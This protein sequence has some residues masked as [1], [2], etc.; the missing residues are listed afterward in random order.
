MKPSLVRLLVC[1]GCGSGL[2][3]RVSA[4]SGAEAQEGGLACRGCAAEYPVVR[5]VPRFVETGA[6]AG[7]FG[8]QWN[9]FR[10]VQ[11][12]SRN[13]SGESARTFS[14]TTGWSEEDVRGKVVLDAGVGAGRFAE[15]VADRGGEVIGIDITSAV[16]AAYENVGRR[17]GVHVIQADIFAM[18]LR[19]GSFDLAYSIGVLHHTPDTRKAF[20]RV[21]SMVRP[22]GQF[23]V[24]L[25]ARYGPS[26]RC[27]DAIR[28]LTTRLPLWLMLR[29]AFL[30]APLYPLYRLP[31]I[32]ALLRLLFP[33]SM[34]PNWRWRWLDTFDWYSP[35]YQ[36][37][38]LYPEV[39]RWFRACGFHDI[40]IFDDPIRMRGTREPRGR[41]LEVPS[42][43][44]FRAVALGGGTGLPVVLQGLKGV[45]FP[46]PCAPSR[47]E[48]E[49]LTAI[50]TVA[51]D[52]GS[53]G[54]LRRL[55]RIVAPGDIRSCL[56]ALSEDR[57]ALAELFRFRFAGEEDVGGHNLGN[58]ILSAL[59]EV[60]GDFPHAVERA[61]QI[62]D[63]RGRVLPS[64]S[65]DVTL[66]AELENGSTVV[67]ECALRACGGRVR[68]MRLHPETVKAWPEAGAAIRSADLVVVGPGS[69]YTSLLPNLLIPGLADA[70]RHSEARVVL[71]MNM[72]TEPGETDG[73]TAADHV[74]AL[75]AH[76]PDLPL[77]TV[78]LHD[79]TIG[80]DRAR[81]Y[82]SQGAT[83]VFP[84]VAALEAL[85]C[86]VV[87]RDLLA[88][89]PSVRHEHGKLA[90]AL[91]EL[92]EDRGDRSHLHGDDAL[93]A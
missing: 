13:G 72:M 36:A 4:W 40:E 38:F 27:S 71:V 17:E 58:L 77:P 41:R 63:V 87:R 32:G 55:Y 86:R 81:R 12:D 29:A 66:L 74:R 83:P 90:A 56:I 93:S 45:L 75:L 82:S 52:G 15:V 68:R 25:Y 9:W 64:T 53:S 37:K 24:Y 49:R 76:V 46:G 22:G 78:L 39:F 11:I 1:P 18:P 60:E 92:V 65:D 50:V 61:G 19:P 43:A 44:G 91:A 35:R 8:R 85:G 89:G 5:G 88:E 23:A 51:D 70:L 33:I 7:T 67:G 2:D 26:H 6:Y 54:R 30:A 69:L 80:D 73:Y 31:A 3:L 42:A 62:L 48:R 10:E 79:G 34:H 59:K 21:A 84:D 57:G 14:A 20:E 16:D 28:T 47:V